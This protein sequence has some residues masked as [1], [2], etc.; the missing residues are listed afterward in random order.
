MLPYVYLFLLDTGNRCLPGPFFGHPSK[1]TLMRVDPPHASHA[2]TQPNSG[3]SEEV[4]QRTPRRRDSARIGRVG[5]EISGG[6]RHFRG[7][8]R[9]RNSARSGQCGIRRVLANIR[10]PGPVILGTDFWGLHCPEFWGTALQ[11]RSRKIL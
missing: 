3:Y 9:L 11:I 7:S 8:W 5:V 4:Y 10:Q 6:N 1:S 2:L